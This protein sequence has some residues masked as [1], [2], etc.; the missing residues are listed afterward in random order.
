MRR[1]TCDRCLLEHVCQYAVDGEPGCKHWQAAPPTW[2]DHRGWR[3]RVMR[4]TGDNAWRACVKRPGKASW[5]CVTALPWRDTEAE[6]QRDLDALAR[7]KK[8]VD[9]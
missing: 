6:A 8:W 2:V 1:R 4:G 5:R 3:Y 7:A 9:A